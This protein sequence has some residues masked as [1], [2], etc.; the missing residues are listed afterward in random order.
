MYRSLEATLHD[1]FWEAEGDSSEL[2]LLHAFLESHP[3][4]C[5]DLGCGSGRLL[6]PLLKDGFEID[7][8]DCSPDMLALCR[9]YATAYG[10]N[11]TLHQQDI[12]SFKLPA[13]YQSV[14]IP[15]FTFQILPNPALA[16]QGIHQHLVPGGALYL[17]VFIPQAELSGDPPEGQWYLDHESVLPGDRIA[18]IHTRHRINPSASFLV[19]E[20]HYEIRNRD[21]SLEDS[22]ESTQHLRWYHSMEL[23]DLLTQH[24]FHVERL[25]ADFDPDAPH[26]TPESDIF[27]I[28]ATRH[29]R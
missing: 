12:Q 4:R 19:R 5:L 2:P 14:I 13:P 6:L 16:L 21:E 22:H 7:G 18:R 8:L 9:E 11:P 25:I 3:G 29:G 15:A 26:P 28:L 27:T 17:T 24:G 20:H 1:P 10:V 23:Q